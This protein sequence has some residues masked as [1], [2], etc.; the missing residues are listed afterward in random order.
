M[1][2]VEATL[3]K[4]DVGRLAKVHTRTIDRLLRQKLIP[5]PIYI[6]AGRGRKLVRFLASD[7]DLWLRLGAPDRAAFEA[8]KREREGVRHDR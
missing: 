8:A 1:P 7:I 5:Q 6:G 2:V 3:T 4:P